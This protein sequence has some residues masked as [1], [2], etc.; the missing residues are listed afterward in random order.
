MELVMFQ[1]TVYGYLSVT[2]IYHRNEIVKTVIMSPFRY[3]FSR[4]LS[5]SPFSPYPKKPIQQKGI[6]K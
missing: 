6:C 2:L 5:Q 4:L 3:S 1:V